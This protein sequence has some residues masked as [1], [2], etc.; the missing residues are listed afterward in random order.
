MVYTPHDV[1]KPEQIAA[2]AAVALEEALVIPA[3]FQREGID[4]FK[5]AKND[6][7]NVKVEGVLPFRSYGFRNDRSTEIQFDTY[8]EKTVQ[9]TFG[10]DNTLPQVNSNGGC[11]CFQCYTGAG[12]KRFKQHV[13]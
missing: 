9:V 8:A 10:G 6:A 3:I 11:N 5:G 12:N 7:I 2:T 4:Q 1:V 13:A